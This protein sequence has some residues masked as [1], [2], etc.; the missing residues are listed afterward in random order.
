MSK[1]KLYINWYSLFHPFKNWWRRITTGAGCCDTFSYYNYLAPKIA[2]G[3]RQFKK[4]K[5]SYPFDLT[6]TE[7]DEI[8]DKMIWS[9]ESIT[10]KEEDEKWA[11]KDFNDK[12]QEGFE[13]FGKYFRSLWY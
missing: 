2:I 10:S 4:R 9:F 5:Y 12:Q 7:W 3:L 6:T 11:D 8:L 1:I 13:L